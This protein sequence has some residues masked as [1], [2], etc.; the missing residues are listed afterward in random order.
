ME[1]FD[2]E[3][4][5]D[6]EEL[7]EFVDGFDKE[8]AKNMSKEFELFLQATKTN[9]SQV[10]RYCQKGML[11]L[12]SAKK[13]RIRNSEIPKC[14][15]CGSK[16]TYEMQFMPILYNYIN[17][18]VNLNWNSV[19]IYTCENSCT[20]TNDSE[21]VEEFA[22]VELIDED[23]RSMNIEGTEALMDPAS[24]YKKPTKPTTN[25]NKPKDKSG[26]TGLDSET[27]AKIKQQLDELQLDL[28]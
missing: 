4:D 8:R 25:T 16:M 12:W 22:Y 24:S 17:E 9:S 23:E 11:P 21:Y 18:L 2:K 10:I 6:D 15:N 20:P 26:K 7:D 19:M 3:E 13:F 5:E 27:E 28:D 1:N 14:N